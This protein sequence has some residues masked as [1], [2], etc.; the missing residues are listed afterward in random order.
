[1]WVEVLVLRE[2]KSQYALP[3]SL[4]PS[5]LVT[6]S[7]SDDGCSPS[8]W[9]LVEKMWSSRSVNQRWK[10]AQER[11]K[12]CFGYFASPD[13]PSIE[14]VGTFEIFFSSRAISNCV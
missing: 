3:H 8:V 2:L 11:N 10:V 4:S 9:A 12:P 13:Q 1:M 5:T 7:V 14:R 6:G